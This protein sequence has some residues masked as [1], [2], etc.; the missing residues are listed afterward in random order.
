MHKSYLKTLQ[1]VIDSGHMQAAIDGVY[2]YP[3]R[4]NLFPGTS[5]MFEC[6]FCGRNYNAVSDVD[7]YFWDTVLDQDDGK[8]IYRFN[9][10]GGLEPLTYKHIDR[11]CKD[12]Y[13]RRYRSR[14]VT[15]GFLL[16]TKSLLKNTYLLSLDHI[17][18]SLYG[19]DSDEYTVTTKHKK[20]YQVVKD[21]LKLYNRFMDT[22]PL[23]LNYVLLPQHFEKLDKIINY[24]DDIGGVSNISL[25]EDFSFQYEITD[26][27]KLMDMINIFDEKIKSRGISVDY[28]YALSQLLE[29]N[30]AKLLRVDH[31][32][33]T[34]KQSPQIKIAIDP[35]GDIYSWLEAA[36]IDR[37]GSDRHI[38][39]NVINSSIEEELKKMKE[40][41][42][43]EADERFLDAFNHVMEYYKW[44]NLQETSQ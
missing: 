34:K 31:T 40:V 6:D 39:G 17:R 26:R 33:L 8:D 43:I 18:V 38:L 13:D 27:N 14:L 12:L 42:P 25:R 10:S 15:N 16:N 29:G 1:P 11:L 5:C 37:E 32:Q 36:F 4:I 2:K 30:I 7:E 24:I 3:H 22:P 41:E 9:I 19:L 21:N 20:G 35:R 44:T 28:G 23:Y